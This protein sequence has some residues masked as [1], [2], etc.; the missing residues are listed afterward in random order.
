[1]SSLVLISGLINTP[2][3]R[4]HFVEKVPDSDEDELALVRV[5]GKSVKAPSLALELSISQITAAA[6]PALGCKVSP[7][8]A[9]RGCELVVT[10]VR[11]VGCKERLSS[12]RYDP[13]QAADAV[14]LLRFLVIRLVSG[15]PHL[16]CQSQKPEAIVLDRVAL[17]LPCIS[18]HLFSLVSCG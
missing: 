12:S 18:C 10:L 11:E 9:Q 4:H 2:P 1:M 5:G 16:R 8:L 15:F 14:L 7:R 3:R 17:F 13:M 6:R